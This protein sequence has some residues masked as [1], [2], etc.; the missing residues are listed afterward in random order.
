M[1]SSLTLL[2]TCIIL[3]ID[4]ASANAFN[5]YRVLPNFEPKVQDFISQVRCFLTSG[6]KQLIHLIKATLLFLHSDP[7]CSVLCY[8]G[9]R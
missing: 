9:Q 3:I 2:P 6:L 8:R 4:N 5:L 7:Q 1:M